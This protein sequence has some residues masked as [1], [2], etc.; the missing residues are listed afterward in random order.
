MGV[1]SPFTLKMTFFLSFL[2][3]VG[4]HY[5]FSQVKCLFLPVFELPMAKW[6]MVGGV[7]A[8]SFVVNSGPVTYNFNC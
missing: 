7:A 2:L 1:N 4:P 3:T 8:L 5:G 6:I